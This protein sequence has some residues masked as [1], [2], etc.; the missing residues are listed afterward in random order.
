[1]FLDNALSL[2]PVDEIVYLL[3]KEF[4]GLLLGGLNH[5]LVRATIFHWVV[6]FGVIKRVIENAIIDV[7]T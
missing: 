7:F 4:F 5:L 1:M 6:A 3:S 2:E